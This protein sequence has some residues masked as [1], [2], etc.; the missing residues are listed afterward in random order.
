M[1]QQIKQP[2]KCISTMYISI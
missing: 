1:L 2:L